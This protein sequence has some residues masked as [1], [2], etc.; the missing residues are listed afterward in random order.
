MIFMCYHKSCYESSNYLK[1]GKFLKVSA[2]W[3]EEK[4]IAYHNKSSLVHA[5]YRYERGMMTMVGERSSVKHEM[6]VIR[7]HVL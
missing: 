5:M 7:V 3:K 2:L 1:N 4:Y 6:K